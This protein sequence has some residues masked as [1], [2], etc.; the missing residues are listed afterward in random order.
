M[1]T[2]YY[3]PGACSLAPHIVLEWIGQPYV[4]KRVKIGSPELVAVNPAGAVPVL[5]EDDGWVLTQNGAILDYLAHKFPEAKLTG[6][7][8]LR[9][10]AE[11]HRWSSFMSSDMHG[12]FW[13]VFLTQRY[14]T[15]TTDEALK[16]VKGAGLNRV[17][18][19][20]GVLDKHLAGREW[21]L[22]EGKGQVSYVDAYAFPMIR[23]GSSVLPNGLAPFPNVQ[24]LHD[25]LAADPA[26]Q[27]VLADES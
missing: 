3:S 11:A 15:E 12:A 18:T 5:Q 25:R 23:W 6:G 4:A 2:L 27:K 21:I 1:T 22:G 13:P 8:S 19:E 7:D 9:E 17:A 14:T 26:V 16:A 20:M 24:A 10:Q